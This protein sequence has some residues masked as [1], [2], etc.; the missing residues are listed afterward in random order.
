MKSEKAY[1]MFNSFFK[2]VAI[3]SIISIAGC[4]ALPVDT[5]PNT[6][7]QTWTFVDGNTGINYNPSNNADY[8][9]LTVFGT[10]LYATWQEI[11]VVSQIQ[12]GQYNGVDSN[13]GWAPLDG[14]ST[15]G[16]NLNSSQ[17]ATSP[18]LTVFGTTL[19]ATWSEI[20]QGGISQ[21]RVAYYNTATAAWVYIDGG[22]ATG[23]NYDPTQ[24]ASTPQLTVFGTT[25]YVTWS[26]TSSTTSA[27]QIRV[28]YYDTAVSPAVWTFVDGNPVTTT[29]INYN[30]LLAGSAPQLTVFNNNLY[31]IWSELNGTASQIRVAVYNGNNSSP[32]WTFVDGGGAAGINYDHTNGFNAFYPQLVVFGSELYATWSEFNGTAYEIR[33][34][35][36]NGTTWPFVD[37]SSPLG[38][39]YDP[40]QTASTPQLTV[41]NN[42]LY[43]IWSELLSGVGGQIRVAVYNGN[44]SSPVWTLTDGGGPVGINFNSSYNAI[45]PQMI[46]FGNELYATW[47]GFNGAV[48]QIQAAVTH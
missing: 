45:H 38:I 17:A 34:A 32:V 43:A 27:P 47:S 14:G 23:I 4:D 29:G 48:Y 13:P 11:N 40:T 15:Q 26:E 20:G 41:F 21:I 9:R 46:V 28:A 8:P 10:G 1:L 36:Y 6:P 30:K 42:N 18:Q 22:G 19:Y 31:A 5:T 7:I 16:I 24:V 39:N 33:I 2:Y 44:D 35:V 3:L 12:V 25:L 37:G